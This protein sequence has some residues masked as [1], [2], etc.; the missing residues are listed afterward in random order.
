[1]HVNFS[2][3]KKHQK[4]IKHECIGRYIE[5]FYA[6]LRWMDVELNLLFEMVSMHFRSLIILR[7][8]VPNFNRKTAKL[9]RIETQMSGINLIL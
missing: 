1:M 7:F 6:K 3:S 9:N 4:F 8:A 2:N 5:S